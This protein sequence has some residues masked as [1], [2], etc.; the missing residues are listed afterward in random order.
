MMD[1]HPDEKVFLHCIVNQRASAFAFLYSVLRLGMPV[2]EAK[3]I[4]QQIWEPRG[5]WLHFIDAVLAS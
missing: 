2:E 3:A 1:V 4:M 5:A